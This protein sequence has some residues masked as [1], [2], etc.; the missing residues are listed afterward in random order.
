MTP[1]ISTCQFEI[2]TSVAVPSPHTARRPADVMSATLALKLEALRRFF[3]TPA[4]L[5]LLP[6]VAAM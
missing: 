3:G 6:A 5:E 1:R 4:S 2:A